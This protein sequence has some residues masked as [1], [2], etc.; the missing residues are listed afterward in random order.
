MLYNVFI[1]HVAE[2]RR[3]YMSALNDG[4]VNLLVDAFLKGEVK[5]RIKGVE[6]IIQNPDKFVIFNITDENL[7]SL[8]EDVEQN[9][10]KMKAFLEGGKINQRFYQSIGS[11]VTDKFLIENSQGEKNSANGKSLLKSKAKSKIF[12]SHSSR[13]KVIADTLINHVLLL[14]M[15]MDRSEIFCT[16]TQGTDIKSGEDFKKAIF[17][18]L[19]EAKA[20]I[21]IISPEYKKSEVCLNEMG[22]AWALTPVVIPLIAP[23]F[24]YDV[25]FIHA[26]TQQTMLNSKEDLLKLYDGYKGDIFPKDLSSSVLVEQIDYFVEFINRY[27][28]EKVLPKKKAETM[29]FYDEEST[30]KG[31]L[32]SAIFGGP[33]WGVEK[34][35]D[36][37]SFHRYYFVELDPEINI[38]SSDSMIEEGNF[39]TTRFNQARIQIVPTSET[40][41][42]DLKSLV[43]EDVNVVGHFWG[44][45]TAWHRT[46]VLMSFNH[47]E[48]AE[49]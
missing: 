31:Q 41:K 1:E 2:D 27:E 15:G 10:R 11:N 18:E 39:N 25:G 22:A 29:L 4:Q 36:N 5:V 8:Q 32:R 42:V 44:G 40:E 17:D 16:S 35:E 26:N 21:Q 7:G 19:K 12:I 20:V 9:I 3:Q 37:A 28:K 30:I 6:R 13:D 43:D 33:P 24:N 23:P 49:K 47:I 34:F 48:K 38:L 14:G 45:H 46:D